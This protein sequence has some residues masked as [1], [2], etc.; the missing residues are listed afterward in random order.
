VGQVTVLSD[1]EAQVTVI[2]RAPLRIGLAGGGTDLPA[3]ADRFGGSVVNVTIDRYVYVILTRTASEALQIT[4]ADANSVL[5]RREHLFDSALFWGADYRLPMEVLNY[6]GVSG[7]RRIF[8]ASEVPPGTG[9]GSSSAT[10][11]ALIRALST[12]LGLG[13]SKR[14]IAEIACHI[15]ID[16]MQMPI[17]RQDQYAAAF[18]GFNVLSFGRG[19]THIEPL[20]VAPEVREELQSRTLLFFTGR[21]RRSTDIL[22]QQMEETSRPGS[23]TLESL[24]ALKAFAQQM[25]RAIESGDLDAIGRLLDDSWTEKRRL[26][27]GVSTAEIDG[28]YAE[29]RAAGAAGGKITGAGGGGFLMLY[30]RPEHRS[31]IIQ[32]MSELGLVWV[33]SMFED[34]GCTPL[35]VT[36]DEVL[37]Y[38]D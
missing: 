5:S 21:R 27:A 33:D 37:A 20:A 14:E 8:I 15:E 9:L 30:A 18:G 29:A 19:G 23:Q 2:A 6:F 24:H 13:L 7:G 12:D 35:L 1:L 10:A 17:G 34:E 22:T 3:Y 25:R 32:R 4:A 36:S 16:R 31:A 26:A 28:W 11:V 38:A